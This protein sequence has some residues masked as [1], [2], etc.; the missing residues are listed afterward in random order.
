MCGGKLQP[1]AGNSAGQTSAAV[2]PAASQASEESKPVR[3]PTRKERV[4]ACLDKILKDQDLPTFSHHISKVMG[5]IGNEELSLRHLNNIILR[6]YS[7]SLAV[8]RRA[9]SA[10][11]NRSNRQICSVAHAITLLGIEAVRSLAATLILFEHY[12]KR[13]GGLKELLLLSLLTAS[14]A[15]QAAAQ[16]RLPRAEEAYLCGMFRN[17]G[18][19]LVATHLRKQYNRILKERG[20]SSSE[21]NVCLQMLGFTYEDLGQGMAR[22]WHMPKSVSESMGS[23]GSS[24]AQRAG[25]DVMEILVAFGHELTDVIY[26]RNP[27]NRQAA[28]ALIV[29][30][31][32]SSLRLGPDGVQALIA[33]AV[34]ETT[35]TFAA[36]KVPLDG[37]QLLRQAEAA[38]QGGSLETGT[39]EPEEEAVTEVCGAEENLLDSLAAEVEAAT[40]SGSSVQMNSILMM[41]LEAYHRGAGFDRVIFFL[42]DS[43]RTRLRGRLGLGE[44]IESMI[45]RLE[46]PLTGRG[47]PLTGLLTGKKDTFA[48]L[49]GNPAYQDSKA[50]RILRPRSFG[51]FPVVVDG[52]AVGCMYFDRLKPESPPSPRVVKVLKRLRDHVA[53]AIRCTRV[54]VGTATVAD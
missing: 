41:V 1:I 46:I 27:D 37:L 47:E 4:Q 34:S 36:A 13:A 26:R 23:A 53:E 19:V 38:L 5:V 21:A 44:D 45:D 6:D 43:D 10:Y 3:P 16:L 30:K 31:Y 17:L 42:A 18:E 2:S 7:L 51:L 15:R 12:N 54:P 22:H 40:Q 28:I 11:Y 33:T 24:P 8:L 48:E 20:N 52:T 49:Q 35:E 29:N 50:L 9:N 39:P 32:G 25:K 14:H